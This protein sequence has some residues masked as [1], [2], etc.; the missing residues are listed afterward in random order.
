MKLLGIIIA[1][2]LLWDKH[3]A[4][5]IS[6][7]N[8]YYATLGQSSGEF[9][10]RLQRAHLHAGYA[11]FGRSAVDWSCALW[12]WTHTSLDYDAK[13]ATGQ[14]LS[15]ITAVGGGDAGNV[16]REALEWLF[17]ELPTAVRHDALR[18]GLAY[19]LAAGAARCPERHA[20]FSVFLADRNPRFVS[21]AITTRLKAALTAL[22]LE[23][24]DTTAATPAQW[25]RRAHTAARDV[26]AVAWRH[27]LAEASTLRRLRQ[28]PEPPPAA[29]RRALLRRPARDDGTR[30]LI[31]V[32][33]G[34]CQLCPSVR[35][36]RYDWERLTR[37]SPAEAEHRRRTWLPDAHDDDRAARGGC[38]W[39]GHYDL[40]VP[41]ADW[42]H[43]ESGECH[44]FRDTAAEWH[45]R[46]HATLAASG[47]PLLAARGTT[48]F[49]QRLGFGLPDRAPL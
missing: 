20:A 26:A 42:E 37:C 25:R 31:A 30:L 18:A 29:W 22:A 4:G 2:T 33:G 17:G 15:L 44:H 9:G 21:S 27:T 40:D 3:I 34:T 35:S 24:P 11:S 12:G 6:A 19:R 39:C 16:K 5:R 46:A 41:L 32:I 49:A 45:C 14:R 47:W 13:I 48:S 10:T 38:D 23:P 36:A 1:N 43:I 7:A 8:G 28:W